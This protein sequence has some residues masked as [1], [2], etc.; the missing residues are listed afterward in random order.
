MLDL[1]MKVL[2]IPVK[3]VEVGEKEDKAAEVGQGKVVHV[4]HG[5]SLQPSVL[6]LPDDV[7]VS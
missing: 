5:A 1:F 3:D 4:I 2:L 7:S 6:N